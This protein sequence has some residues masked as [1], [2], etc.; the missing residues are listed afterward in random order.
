MGSRSGSVREN[1]GRLWRVSREV[2]SGVGEISSG[3]TE[4]NSSMTHL[5]DLSRKINR[6]SEELDQAVAV[7]HLDDEEI[8]ETEPTLTVETP[9]ESLPESQT[10]AGTL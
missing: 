9:M 6:I 5:L 10:E 8:D 4:V 2:T 7:F 1:M 3:L